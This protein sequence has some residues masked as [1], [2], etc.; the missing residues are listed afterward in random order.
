MRAR[1]NILASQERLFRF[2]T[3]RWKAEFFIFRFSPEI[4][5][6]PASRRW[7]IEV[8]GC[9]DDVGS[10]LVAAHSPLAS[11]SRFPCRGCSPGDPVRT[12]RDQQEI[13]PASALSN[14]AASRRSGLDRFRWDQ[15]RFAL[16]GARNPDASPRENAEEQ[17]RCRVAV[18]GGTE[19]PGGRSFGSLAPVFRA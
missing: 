9:G 18:N 13:G 16:V 14:L 12:T 3:R 10:E 8:G 17:S 1:N 5:P 4:S 2:S 11:H 15:D 19:Y 7:R 6:I